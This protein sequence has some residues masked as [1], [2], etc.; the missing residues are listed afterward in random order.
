M[1]LR[2]HPGEVEEQEL[3]RKGEVFGE[4]AEA[5]E[6]AGGP[7]QQCLVRAEAG[8]ARSRRPGTMTGSGIHR[9]VGIGDRD[10][11]AARAARRAAS[12]WFVGPRRKNRRRSTPSW[13]KVTS[14]EAHFSVMRSTPAAPAAAGLG[15]ATIGRPE[16][17][18]F[19]TSIGHS[20]TGAVVR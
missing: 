6:A 11:V 20:V 12:V 5:G 16:R 2:V 7:G 14:G 3:L 15:G 10:R 4:Q 19:S 13:V 9:A 8:R 17:R 1:V 18:T